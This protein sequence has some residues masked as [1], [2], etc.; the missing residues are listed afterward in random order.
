MHVLMTTDT[1]GGVWIYTQELVTQLLHAGVR[2]TLVSLGEIPS[3]EQTS[4]MEGLPGLD[5]LP[6]GF[7]LEWMHDAQPDMEASERYLES[8]IEEI[9]PDL[10]HFN[11]YYYGAISAPQPRV[12]VAHSDVVGW[13]QAVHGQEPPATRWLE[14][15]RGMIKRG[16]AGAS[17]VVAP[18]RWMLQSLESNYASGAGEVI[19]NGRSPAKFN[20]HMSKEEFALS[21]GRVWDSGKQ[22]T[23]LCSD[24]L[25]L[26][27][28]VVGSE[29]H[30]DASL[31][32][33][34]SQPAPGQFGRL[35]I[36]GEQ[37]QAQL[38]HLYGRAAIYAATSRY[39]PF[40]L[41]PLEAALSR[42][43]I[44]ANDIPAFREIWGDAACYFERNQRESLMATLRALQADQALRREF[45]NRAYH[46]ALSH[47][48]AERMAANYLKLYAELVPAV[49]LAA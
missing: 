26:D 16:L 46:H 34:S 23:L 37:S 24:D 47:F 11:Q 31:R 15:Y 3:S 36:A 28:V 38:R 42:C 35:R 44:L 4:W 45:A 17:A 6:T 32:E 19:C 29:R 9:Q 43:A 14:W 8:L 10:L 22:A 30:P 13:W 25:P 33:I 41:A 39:E 1:V 49:A 5:F 18:S 2:V 27:C 7:A 48:T 12:V 20:P 21:V 40:G